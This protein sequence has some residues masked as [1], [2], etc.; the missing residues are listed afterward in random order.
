MRF[1]PRPGIR[2]D[3]AEVP[4]A[5]D[6]NNAAGQGHRT[7]RIPDRYASPRGRYLSQD[8]LRPVPC[9]SSRHIDRPPML[10]ET[11]MQ[12][13]GG[14]KS[15]EEEGRLTHVSRKFYDMSAT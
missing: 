9:R 8:R 7:M 4:I 10:Y 3:R 12:G 13:P 2:C 1:V 6:G 15:T 14:V 5:P 11:L